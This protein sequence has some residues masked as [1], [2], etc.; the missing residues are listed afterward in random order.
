MPAEAG[1]LREYLETEPNDRPAQA[2]RIETPAVCNGRIDKKGDVDIWVFIAKKGERFEFDLR[3]ASLGSPLEAT[4]LLA[5]AADK[6]LLR[7]GQPA[8][9][10]DDLHV[11][12]TAPAD[13]S[14][15]IRIGSRFH[16]QAGPECAYRLAILRPGAPDFRLT[17][18]TDALTLLRGGEAKLK[19]NMERDGDF[20]GPVRLRVIGLPERVAATGALIAANQLA[21]DVTFKAEPHAHVGGC[22][23][24]IEGSADIGGRT[25]THRATLVAE[26]GLPEEDTVLLA[27]GLST[28]FKIAGDSE[29]RWAPRGTVFHRRYRI[30]RRGYDG[31]VQVSLAD[32]QARHLQGVTGPTII[33]SPGKSDFDYSIRLPAWMEPGRTCRVCIMGVGVVKDEDGIERE[34]GF[35]SV[36]QNIQLVTV[37][38][39][40]RLGIEAERSSVAATPGN[41]VSVPVRIRREKSLVGPV[42]L[43]VVV[44]THIHG[45]SAPFVLVPA[46]QERAHLALQFRSPLGP[47]NMPLTIRATVFDQG[48]PVIA[49]TKLEIVAEQTD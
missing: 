34:V 13:G 45:V 35:T 19:I 10:T 32:R 48:E 2:T 23:L 26:R 37:I 47:F 31:P 30:D 28:P 5:D 9:S 17:F 16:Y 20:H 27:V 41:T 36:Q 21:S 18:A 1:E 25:V 40:G 29:F 33:V 38:E 43:D 12:W 7:T 49:E 39:P 24:T 14:Y 42:R 15:Q 4:F 8:G 3:T 46:D 22:R 11:A 44:P 6:P